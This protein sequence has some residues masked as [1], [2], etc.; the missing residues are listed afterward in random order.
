MRRPA[1]AMNQRVV[2]SGCSAGGKSTLLEEL[3]RRGHAVVAEPGRRIVEQEQAGAGSALPWTDMQAFL[4]RAARLARLDYDGAGSGRTFF[5]RG[6]VDAAA[7][8]ARLGNPSLLEQ[9][10]HERRYHE[11]VFLAPPWPELYQRDSQRQ[12]ALEDALR[13]YEHLLEVYPRLGYEVLILPRTGVA[14]RADWLLAQLRHES[15]GQAG[16]P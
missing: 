15:A 16:T 8:L 1:H 10:R 6:L 7:G 14:E 2:I 3:R 11:Q 13:E 12:L 5:D 9:L 4:E